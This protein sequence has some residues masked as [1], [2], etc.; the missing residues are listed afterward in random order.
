MFNDDEDEFLDRNLGEHI[1]KFESYL[2][3]DAFFF[4]DSDVL[5]MIVDH[6][7]VNG[8]YTKAI[9][10]AEYGLN[11][12]SPNQLFVLRIAQAYSAKGLL[13][14]A[15]NMLNNKDDFQENLI[16]YYLTKAS[17][18]SQLKNSDNAIKFFKMALDL[19]ES[20]ER[21]EIYL[22]IAMEYQYKGDYRAAIEVLNEAIKSNPKNEVALYEVAYCYDFIGEFDKAI[23]CYNNFI[24]ENP[25]SYTAWY[26][27]G[28][29]YS[30]VE[31]W[32]NALRA[33]DFCNVINEQFSPVYFNMGNAFLSLDRYEEAEEVFRKCIEMEGDDALAF[34]YLGES[35]E[36]QGKIQEAKENYNQAIA[37]NPVL[38]DAWLGLGIVCDLEGNTEKGIELIQK[39]IDLEPSNAS[40]YH[41]LASAYDKIDRFEESEICF[42]KSLELDAKNEDAIKDFYIML[43]STAQWNKAYRLLDDYEQYESNYLTVSLLR[44]HWYWNNF[45]QELALEI[46]GACIIEDEVKSKQIF[47]WFEDLS[48]EPQVTSLF[49]KR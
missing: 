3:G 9:K 30:K 22:D 10:A 14:E 39:A 29:I 1:E 6:Y 19:T 25:Y 20:D 45:N 17:I 28:N 21:D 47:E 38:S 33:Y 2:K 23:E 11:Y 34:C 49:E 46:L 8:D 40:Y 42:L 13:K 48:K 5:E 27:L 35:L 37:I 15:L 18:F 24:D 31:D 43:F 44:F 16:E 41:V 32:D 12:F 7:I 36:Q 4:F 26:N